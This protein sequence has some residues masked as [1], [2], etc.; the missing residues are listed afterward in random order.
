MIRGIAQVAVVVV[1]LGSVVGC[2]SL[3]TL[4][5]EESTAPSSDVR[6]SFDIADGIVLRTVNYEIS[7]NGYLRQGSIDVSQSLGL[8]A[9]IGGIPVGTGYTI[10]VTATSTDGTLNCAASATFSVVENVMTTVPLHLVC[11]FGTRPGGVAVTTEIDNCP[12]V[13]SLSASPLETGVGGSIALRAHAA[14]PDS[15]PESLSLSWSDGVA[16][17]SQTGQSTSAISLQCEQA[18]TSRITVTAADADCSQGASVEITC[19]GGDVTA[20]AGRASWIWH[21]ISSTSWRE[22]PSSR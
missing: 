22:E 11:R 9:M 20:P 21:E 10:T 1:S 15:P 19:T 8:S 17:F 14:D 4:V 16:S 18:G 12:F 2:S 7:G 13:D 6:L 5:T 3:A